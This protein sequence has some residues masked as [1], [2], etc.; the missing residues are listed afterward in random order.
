MASDTTSTVI[1]ELS[2]SRSTGCRMGRLTTDL[3]GFLGTAPVARQ[4]AATALT[5][6]TDSTATISTAVNAINAALKAYGLTV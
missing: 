4:A 2:D 5:P 6:A 3:I 1:L